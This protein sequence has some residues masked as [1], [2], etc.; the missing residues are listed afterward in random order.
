MMPRISIT[1]KNAL[2]YLVLL[3]LTSATLGYAIYRISSNKVRENALITLVHNNESVVLQF[4][5]FL[6]DVRRDVWY[7]SK[8]PFLKDFIEQ[9]ND[10]NLRGKLAT[11]FLAMLAAKKHYGQLRVISVEGKGKER[12]RVDQTNG[13]FL[14][15]DEGSLQTKGD[16]DYF[17][18]TIQLPEDSI[19]CSEINLNQ[20]YGKIFIPVVPTLRVAT[21]LFMNGKV[22]GIV[23]INVDLTALFKQL[24]QL[25]GSRNQLN[26]S[27]EK[28]FY[29]IHPDSAQEF[30]F[31]FD[32]GPNLDI[33]ERRQLWVTTQLQ[34]SHW[35]AFIDKSQATTII[36]YPY[37]RKDYR[38]YFMLSSV[39]ADLQSVF[40]Q[41]KLNLVYLTLLIIL[42]SVAI[43]IYWTRRQAREF[44]EITHSI[45]AFGTNPNVVN[46]NIERNDEIGDLV[47]SFQE[48][49]GR[50]HHYVNEL[51][52]A[53]NEADL[54]NSAKQSF[55][56]NMS[57]EM[58]NPLQSIL[59]MTNMLEQHQPRPDQQS[60][61]RNLKF[62]AQHLLTL[63]NDVLDYRKLLNDQIS[64]QLQETRL[65]EY[66]GQIIKA[67]LFEASQKKIKLKLEL[68]TITKETTVQIDPV[69][70]SQ[71]INNLLTNAI[72][73]SPEESEV[74]LKAWLDDINLLHFEIL[75]QGP[76]IDDENIHNILNQKPVTGKARLAQNVG[77]GL[78]IVI[79][80]LALMQTHL[81]IKKRATSGMHFAFAL[82]IG[83]VHQSLPEDSLSKSDSYLNKLIPVCACIDDDPQNA[84]YYKHVFNMM[85]IHADV[86]DAPAKFLHHG[87][88]YPF[89]LS[90]INFSDDQVISYLDE[91][92]NKLEE[93][94]IL[95]LV[96]A[97]DDTSKFEQL[98]IKSHEL[99][100][101]KPVSQ[102]QLM[103]A[104]EDKLFSIYFNAP[105]FETLYSLYDKD[106]VKS[107]QALEL[108]IKEWSDFFEKLQMAIPQN[109]LKEFD[110]ITHRLANSMR[111]LGLDDLEQ[112]MIHLRNL[113][114]NNEA[115]KPKAAV[116]LLFAYQHLLS[117][118]SK[119]LLR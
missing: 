90:D 56:E 49:S 19:Y 83:H 61:I 104:L 10:E 82:P 26:L 40:D 24:E 113:M 32:M 78:P 77:L 68:S 55:I 97:A 51:R 22:W 119:E 50:I 102:K 81:I 109:D 64:L 80:L 58:R 48:M 5:A 66:L 106:Q 72:R 4:N 108:L 111:L 16:R 2:V 6:D 62:S 18:E 65:E 73:Y 25:A 45:S 101:Q 46:L 28:G 115:E 107:K 31:E 117:V 118:F 86:F 11:E 91:F 63:V 85:G 8:N 21:P 15:V 74:L 57:H 23:I 7:L 105:V 12:L 17:R 42:G 112:A 39:D 27:N 29:L 75:D 59:G 98:L 69:R 110:R 67:Q 54:A 14:I 103:E 20:E 96:S 43:A 88:K 87:K 84:F 93:P 95:F 34:S 41:W 36:E 116:K 3:V 70:L 114:N 1:V 53:K 94:G 37:P 79:R 71:I 38:L 44:K 30:L 99:F 35:S 47:K 33:L 52:L 89:I 76:G 60:F 9:P 92:R 13:K 100:L